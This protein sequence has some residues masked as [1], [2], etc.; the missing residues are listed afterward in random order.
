MSTKKKPAVTMRTRDAVG[1]LRESGIEASK[2]STIWAFPEE[3]IIVDDPNHPLFDPS[4]YAPLDQDFVDSIR[5]RGVDSPVLIWRD[6]IDGTSGKM[7]LLVV[8]GRQRVRASLLVNEER[9]KAGQEPRKV[10]FIYK[11][12]QPEDLILVA[13]EENLRSNRSLLSRAWKAMKALELGHTRKRVAQASQVPENYLDD[14]ISLVSMDPAAQRAFELGLLPQASLRDLAMV[15]RAEQGGVVEKLLSLG[16]TKSHQVRQAVPQIRRGEDVKVTDKLQL[17]RRGQI[18]QWLENISASGEK[19]VAAKAV[20]SALRLVLGF[21]DAMDNEF[22]TLH[23]DNVEASAK[24]AKKRA[25]A[26]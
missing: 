26:E 3:F 7:R 12:G 10:P 20:Q 9:V 11:T 17:M 21:S 13:I 25:K 16:T 19:T 18:E 23:P 24:A 22:Q 6:G 5:Q 4:M 14:L 8:G 15:P 2:T 1:M